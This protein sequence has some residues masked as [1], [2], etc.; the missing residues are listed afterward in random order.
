M[1]KTLLGEVEY[2]LA[3]RLVDNDLLLQFKKTGL[4]LAQCYG[5]SSCSGRNTA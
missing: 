2:V 1:G 4:I 3:A 5:A